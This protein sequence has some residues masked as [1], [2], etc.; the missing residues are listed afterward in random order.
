M[1]CVAVCDDEE[2]MADIIRQMAVKFF[3]SKSREISVCLFSS[4]EELLASDQ[5]MDILF[6]DIRMKTMDGLEAAGELRRRGWGGYGGIS[7]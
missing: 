1:I 6:L 5:K 2:Y 7:G 4:G 3:R